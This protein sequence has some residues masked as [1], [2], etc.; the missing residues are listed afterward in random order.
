MKYFLRNDLF[1]NAYSL[2]IRP[3]GLEELHF[4]Y[5]LSFLS[6]NMQK[7]LPI[8][9]YFAFNRY[10]EQF[11]IQCEQNGFMLRWTF[12]LN[13]QFQIEGEGTAKGWFHQK[14][15]GDQWA[16]IMYIYYFE[17]QNE[18]YNVD[19]LSQSSDTYFQILNFTFRKN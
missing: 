17:V 1:Q 19:R 12:F 15:R 5:F 2:K 3:W 10:A 18:K 11:S 9:E 13:R 14:P 16:D 7:C 6:K 4:I 8:A